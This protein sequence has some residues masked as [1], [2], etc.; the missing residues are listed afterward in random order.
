MRW[1][2]GGVV[3]WWRELRHRYAHTPPPNHSTTMSRDACPT[4]RQGVHFPAMRRFLLGW[5]LALGLL[6]PGWAA[7]QT[8]GEVESIGFNN[9][10]RPNCWTPM[11]VRIRPEKSGTFQLQVV[12]ED[13]DKDRPI[14]TRTVAL[15]GKDEGGGEQRFWVYFIPQ[16]TDRGLLDVN[17]QGTIRDLQNQVKV[18]LCTDA[19]A[20]RKSVV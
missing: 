4:P 15:T 10:Y 9:Y 3:E 1:S 8:K 13:L 17:R 14:F 2:C 6:V 5:V 18:F 20:D 7:A 11:V 19:P 16:P 12:Q